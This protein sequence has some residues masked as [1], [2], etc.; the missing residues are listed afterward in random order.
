[1]PDWPPDLISAH[2]PPPELLLDVEL[3]VLLLVLEDVLVDVL[4]DVLE[5]VLLD[6]LE[7]VELDELLPPLMLPADAVNVTR[8]S[9]EPSSRRSMRSVCEPADKLLNVAGLNVPQPLVWVLFC[10]VQEP[11]SIL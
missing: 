8:S 4:L 9:C 3:E 5:D 7:L 2:S 10:V 11:E 1:L 6:V